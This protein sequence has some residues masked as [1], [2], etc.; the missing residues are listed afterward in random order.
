M[1]M[2]PYTYRS[3]AVERRDQ[4][5]G[6]ITYEVWDFRQESYRRLCSINERYDGGA[7]DKSGR[8]LST[9]KADAEL[10]C[11]ALNALE[12]SPPPKPRKPRDPVDAE[13]SRRLI[14]P[15]RDS[16]DGW[17]KTREQSS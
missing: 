6:S 17:R 15:K 11:H 3:Y 9:A 12:G 2:K 16:D 4:D 7:E 1:P 5:D 8:A 14:K 10:I 13:P